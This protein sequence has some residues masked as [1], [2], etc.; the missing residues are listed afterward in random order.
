MLIYKY[1]ILG[2]ALAGLAAVSV[3][4][5]Q[6]APQNAPQY[7]PQNAAQSAAEGEAGGDRITLQQFLVQRGRIFDRID[8]NHDGQITA[9]EI[10]AFQAR[11]E[12][13]RAGAMIRSGRDRPGGGGQLGLL[14]DLTANGPLT[15]AQW[16]QIMT[17]RF[18]RLDTAGL[19]FISR[20]QMRG[21]RAGL[22]G[23]EGDGQAPPMAPQR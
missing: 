14:E 18:Q 22:M 11:M 13:A 10:S 9:D 20:A 19:G 23:Q 1:A 16:D 3:V 7:A 4:H 5:A 8:A 15:R 12:T 17:R 6:Y 2:A 21:R